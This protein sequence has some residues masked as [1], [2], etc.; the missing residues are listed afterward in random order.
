MRQARLFLRFQKKIW[1]PLL[2]V[3]LLYLLRAIIKPYLPAI[4]QLGFAAFFQIV[5]VVIWI[6]I[7]FGLMGSRIR[8]NKYRAGDLDLTWDDYRGNPPIVSR[9]QAFVEYLGGSVDYDAMGGEHEP[10]VLLEGAP[11]VGK[12]WL[13]KVLASVAGVPLWAVDCQSLLGTFVGIGPLKVTGLF[14]GI[15]NEAIKSG[16]GAILFLDEIDSIGGARGGMMPGRFDL[17]LTY[18][19]FQQMPYMGGM[20]GQILNTILGELDGMNERVSWFYRLRRWIAQRL[21][22]KE[23]EWFYPNREFPRV[24]VFCSTNR[25]DILDPALTRRGRIGWHLKV[26][27]PTVEGLL[28]VAYYYLNEHKHPT[29]VKGISYEEEVTPEVIAKTAAGQTPADIKYVLNSAVQLAHRDGRSAISVGDWMGALAEGTMGSKN[30]LPLS[31]EERQLLA[32]HEAGHAIVLLAVARGRLEP[33][34]ITTERYGRALGHMYP[35]ETLT[36]YLGATEEMMEAAICMFFAGAASEEVVAGMRHNSMGGD[37]PP[38]WSLLRQMAFNGM[39]GA[40]PMGPDDKRPDKLMKARME[41]LWER[42]KQIVNQNR[43][44]FDVLVPAL[45]SQKTMEGGQVM[46]LIHDLVVPWK[47]EEKGEQNENESS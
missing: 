43:A 30:P 29:G 36:W 35:V 41:A 1:I 38:I 9:V 24:M 21:D 18:G 33:M 12:T 34:F 20:G 44:A 32:T 19:W 8:V 5:Q 27:K 2:I 10:G 45:V 16:K 31:E 40:F 28:D 47:M 23:G 37:I 4:Y 46:D 39:L 13:A 3:A 26:D 15:R 22:Y 7:F 17:P 42:T 25:P 14:R 11:G 6:Y